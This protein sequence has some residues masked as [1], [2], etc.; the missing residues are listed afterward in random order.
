[1]NTVRVTIQ[2]PEPFAFDLAL[3]YLRGSPSTIAEDV[4]TERYQRAVRLDPGDRLALLTV[5]GGPERAFE[6]SLT[7]QD[8]YS[9][10]VIAAEGLARKIFSLDADLSGFHS[11]IADDPIFA[12]LVRD[13][14]G[15]R[16]VLI[17]DVFE[18]IVWAIIGQQI[19]IRFAAKCKRALIDR[20]GERLTV[21]GREYLVFPRAETLATADEGELAAMQYSRQKIRYILGLARGVVDGRINL[22]SLE[23]CPTDE[24]INRLTA[25]NGIGRWTAEYVLMRGLGHRDVIP[26]ADGG[27]RRVIGEAYGH[28]R[29][30]TEAEVRQYAEGWAGWRSYAAFYWWFTL[31]EQT[32]RRNSME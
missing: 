11:A 17:P 18:T 25:I 22:P 7:G 5:R 3:A 23:G 30:A 4:T 2:P 21:N 27:L 6:V 24:A 15:L 20:Y 28:R 19:N 9:D 1:M 29:S 10:D 31:Q 8:L 14:R 16:P 26:A 13:Y 32:R 12:A